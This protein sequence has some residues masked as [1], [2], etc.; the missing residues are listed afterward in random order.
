MV[1]QVNSMIRTVRECTCGGWWESWLLALPCRHGGKRNRRLSGT[2]ASPTWFSLHVELC[3]CKTRASSSSQVK[4]HLMHC[5]P[6]CL[7]RWL[8]SNQLRLPYLSLTL[9]GTSGPVNCRSTILFPPSLQHLKI[10]NTQHI[11]KNPPFLLLLGVPIFLSLLSPPL[12]LSLS[13][14]FIRVYQFVGSSETFTG[15]E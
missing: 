2:H 6:L 4:I 11:V 10:T 8:S 13:S 15:S 5:K 12:S 7:F 14:T 3:L 9:L 1:L